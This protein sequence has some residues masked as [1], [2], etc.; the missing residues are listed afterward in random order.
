MWKKTYKKL[1]L[2]GY[3]WFICFLFRCYLKSKVVSDELHDSEKHSIIYLP[4]TKLTVKQVFVKNDL[5]E[6]VHVDELLY[7]IVPKATNSCYNLFDSREEFYPADWIK[8][9]QEFE[10]QVI[11]LTGD[12]L[13]GHS[14]QYTQQGKLYWKLAKLTFV[15]QIC[16]IG[17]NAGHSAF[18]WL[19]A[20][21]KTNLLSFDLGIHKYV[22]PMVKYIKQKFKDRLKIY[23]GHSGM[24][25]PFASKEF[26]HKCDLLIIDGGHDFNTAKLDL[27]Q[28]KFLANTKH[29]L[30]ILD[31]FPAERNKD[32][33][34]KAWIEVIQEGLI[35]S[36]LECAL[37][38]DG[39]SR[40]LS[41]GTYTFSS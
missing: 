6:Y 13:E 37:D 21:N 27:L 38:S 26:R 7:S 10:L 35:R 32:S 22:R 15:K 9:R 30:I 39:Q 33:V 31:D 25:V 17:F 41:I 3:I 16:E 5:A 1:F 14:G 2:L 4:S 8:K 12:A 24:S 23:Y 29:N 11:Q 19:S 34:G 18:T 20:N 40:G 36:L 28:M